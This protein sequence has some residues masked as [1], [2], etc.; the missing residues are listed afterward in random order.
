MEIEIFNETNE[1]ISLY[2]KDLKEFLENV[3]HDEKLDN[4]YAIFRSPIA[5]FGR[6]PARKAF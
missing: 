2:L 4:V 3:C 6:K 5:F 1:D